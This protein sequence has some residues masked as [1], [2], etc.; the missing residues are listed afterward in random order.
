MRLAGISLEAEDEMEGKTVWSE[1]TNLK[2]LHILELSEKQPLFPTMGWTVDLSQTP[3]VPDIH[4]KIHKHCS[5]SPDPGT[6]LAGT[7]PCP[8][9]HQ[10]SDLRQVA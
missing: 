5:S 10:R 7:D 1:V 6:R 2:P 4:N 9:P 8:T 3:S